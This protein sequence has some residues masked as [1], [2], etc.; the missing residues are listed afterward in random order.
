MPSHAFHRAFLLEELAQKKGSTFVENNEAMLLKS[1]R[2]LE[3][4]GKLL[5]DEDFEKAKLDGRKL[6]LA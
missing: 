4:Q 3:Q 5:S 6:T 1:L 2:Y